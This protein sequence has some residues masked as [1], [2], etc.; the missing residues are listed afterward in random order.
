MMSV[1]FTSVVWGFDAGGV[2]M[3]IGI[4]CFGDG[5]DSLL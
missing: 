1:S 5:L 2:S 3:A 4:A